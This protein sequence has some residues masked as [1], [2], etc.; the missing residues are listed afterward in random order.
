MPGLQ[1]AATVMTMTLMMTTIPP[2]ATSHTGSLEFR[3]ASLE[4]GT[5][6]YTVLAVFDNNVGV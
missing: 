1:E 4:I 3:R 5:L 2:A 6:C